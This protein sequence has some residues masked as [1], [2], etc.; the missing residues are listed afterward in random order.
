ML[1]RHL[2]SNQKYQIVSTEFDTFSSY[3]VF[4]VSGA[5]NTSKKYHCSSSFSVSVGKTL[6]TENFQ[7]SGGFFHNLL[8]CDRLMSMYVADLSAPFLI[9]IRCHRK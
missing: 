2:G 4:R 8:M 3:S 5:N 6:G 7:F 9:H 1:G